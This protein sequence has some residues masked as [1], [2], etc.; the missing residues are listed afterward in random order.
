MIVIYVPS[1]SHILGV[2]M[3]LVRFLHWHHWLGNS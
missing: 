1:L 3:E 2:N